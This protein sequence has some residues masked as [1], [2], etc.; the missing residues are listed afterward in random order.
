[1]VDVLVFGPHPDDLE[2]CCGGLVLKLRA[3]GHTVG[4]IDMTRGE[5]GTRGTPGQRAA[6]AARGAALLGLAFRENLEL[7]DGSIEADRA[8]R[9]LVIAAIRRHRPQLVVAPLPSDDHP[10]HSRTGQLVKEARFLAGCSRIGPEGEPWRP[11]RV[12]FYPSREPL[13]PTLVID[14]S[15]HFAAKLEAIRAHASQ[16]HDPDSGE[17]RTTIS[18][19][20]FL[21]MI[22]ATNRYFGGLIGVR[23]GEGYVLDGPVAVEDPIAAA[24]GRGHGQFGRSTP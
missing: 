12:L 11:A 4:G 6:E 13:L 2:I 24:R 10:D 21:P 1:M 3:R 19:P 22:E 18:S 9:D 8:S 15:E 17:A 5:S 23:F 7:P 16:L 14:I 20:D